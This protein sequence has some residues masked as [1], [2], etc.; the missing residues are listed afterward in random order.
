MFAGIDWAADTHAVAVHDHDTAKRWRCQIE[1]SAAGLDR[2]VVW[3]ARFG[4]PACLPV[5]IERP[6]GRLVD[7]LLEAGHPVV[8]VISTP[9]AAGFTLTTR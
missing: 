5:A 7:R 6:D 1:H 4:D 3:L 2:L 8:P 9:I